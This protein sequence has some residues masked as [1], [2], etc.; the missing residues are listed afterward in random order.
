MKVFLFTVHV[1][2][3]DINRQ[4]SLL[5]IPSETSVL[6]TLC[7]T[8]PLLSS[9]QTLTVDLLVRKLTL[10]VKA[11]NGE[12]KPLSAVKLCTSWSIIFL[13][14]VSENVEGYLVLVH[15]DHWS[16]KVCI[17]MLTPLHP[18]LVNGW[19][20]SPFLFFY[21]NVLMCDIQSHFGV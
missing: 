14:C 9:S 12:V 21:F 5:T 13:S 11:L 1:N 17:I 10:F 16:W 4:P 3:A 18:P 6:Q 8:E 2:S 20:F 19:Q 15:T 7:I